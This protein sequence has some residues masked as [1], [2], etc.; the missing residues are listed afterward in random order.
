M[1][2]LLCTAMVVCTQSADAPLRFEKT[3]AGRKVVARLPA[4]LAG[5][6][7]AGRLTQEQGQTILT[8]SLLAD[9]A[10]TPGPSMLGKYERAGNELTFT[11]RSPLNAGAT[12]RASLKAG[13]VASLDYRVPMLAPK[14]PPRVVKIYPSA[15]VL[16]ANHLRFYIYFDRPM[17]GGTG[18]FKHLAILDDKGQEVEEPWLVDEIWDEEHNCL[19]LFIHPGRIKWGVELRELMGP[20]LYKNRSYALV[21]RGEWTDL[22]GNK[23]GKDTIKK[24]RTTAEDRVRIELGD[25]KL[26][27]PAAGTRDAVTLT[28]PKSVD[29][30][31][32]YTGLTVM[33]GKG[34]TIE[35]AIAVGKGEKS[36]R[37][38]PS[39]P[40]QAG[41]YHVGV[42]PDL[43]DVAGNTP[44]RPF[45]MD[46]LTP[47]RPAQ[48][49]ELEFQPR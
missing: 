5:K 43:E 20:V 1:R 8:L 33:N 44:S 27:A 35:G 10:K 14:A 36:W 31:S 22:E 37:F 12:Y 19:I 21:V 13:T 45:D 15:D 38:T 29:Y 46:L 17:R 11:P 3:P 24:F 32:L 7:P 30:R 23:I 47:K 26:A 42:S 41:P 40:W 9:D 28:L 18:L 48:K 4:E 49:L 2:L 16:P 25:W 39:A 6:L 34:R